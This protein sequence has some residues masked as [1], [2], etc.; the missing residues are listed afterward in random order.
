MKIDLNNY[1]EY[2]LMYADKELSAS[3]RISVERFVIENPLLAEE[4]E[5]FKAAVLQPDE[6]YLT[7]KDQFKKN[8]EPEITAE[9]QLLNLYLDKELSISEAALFE[10]KLFDNAR[11]AHEVNILKRA[12][13]TPDYNIV[14]P[15]KESLHRHEKK[16]IPIYL[17]RLAAAAVLLGFGFWVGSLFISKN[18]VRSIGQSTVTQ[19]IA[20]KAAPGLP[21]EQKEVVVPSIINEQSPDKTGEQTASMDLPSDKKEQNANHQVAVNNTQ[22]TNNENIDKDITN[23]IISQEKPASGMIT[24]QLAVSEPPIAIQEQPLKISTINNNVKPVSYV[25]QDFN[26]D[27]D[28]KNFPQKEFRKSKLGVFLKKASRTLARNL[29]GSTND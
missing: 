3:E 8:I 5:F 27:D 17:M 1:E 20:E 15:D 28:D 9:Q 23:S 7:N 11:L 14:F 13:H 24:Q 21:K 6:I 19:V 18:D 16:G 26:N 12:I 10:K 4:F 29:K 22:P 2:F 25:E